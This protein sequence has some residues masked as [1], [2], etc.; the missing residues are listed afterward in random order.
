MFSYDT[1]VALQGIAA[2]WILGKSHS[3]KW[4]SAVNRRGQALLPRQDEAAGQDRGW[5]VPEVQKTFALAHLHTQ[6]FN[7]LGLID[8]KRKLRRKNAFLVSAIT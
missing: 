1:T 5:A 2:S 6:V 8:L 7:G 3:R 4:Q